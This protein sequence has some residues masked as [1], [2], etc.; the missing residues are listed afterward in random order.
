MLKTLVLETSTEI[1]VIGVRGEND[2]RL[3]DATGGRR[4]HGR[5]LIPIIQNMIG[6]V[7]FSFRDLELIGVGLGPGSYTGLRIGVTAAKML[8]YATGAVVVG[9]GSL[10]AIAR[11]A[12]ADALE[13]AVIADAQGDEL[14]VAEFRRVQAGSPLVAHGGVRVQAIEPWLASRPKDQL[15]IGPAL[16][17]ARIRALLPP[18]LASLGHEVNQPRW[19]AIIEHTLE[20]HAAGIRHDPWTLE[21][22]YLRRSSAEEKHT[23]RQ[24]AANAEIP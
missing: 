4:R 2:T 23:A 24:K 17:S 8:A 16:E 15:V 7:G 13:L 11:N 1:G 21:P 6:H 22:N 20:A 10:E 5:D 18:E 12:P 3:G 19:Q 14:Y 9:F